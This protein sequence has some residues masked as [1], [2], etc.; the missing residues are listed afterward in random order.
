MSENMLSPNCCVNFN[1]HLTPAMAA[2]LDFTTKLSIEMDYLCLK[3][4]GTMIYQR[5]YH[6]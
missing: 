1:I 2:I 3:T 4:V 5:S 6:K